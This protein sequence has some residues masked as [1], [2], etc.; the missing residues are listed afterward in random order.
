M[1]QKETNM[2]KQPWYWTYRDCMIRLAGLLAAA[3]FVSNAGA[4]L[5]AATTTPLSVISQS[6]PLAAAQKTEYD[7]KAAF[8]YN[9]I[10]FI[11]WSESKHASQS[12]TNK[13]E[14]IRIGVLGK[15]PFG[16]AFEPIIN[17]EIQGRKIQ[18]VEFKSFHDFCLGYSSKEKA[19]EAYQEAYFETL[20][21]CEILFICD[22]E[23]DYRQELLLM[24]S[25][26]AV[27]TL[28]D[29]DGFIEN[30]GMIGFLV[31]NNKVRFEI[32]L[33]NVHKENVKIGSQL[34]GLAK[35]VIKNKK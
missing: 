13:K 3:V 25:G 31:E 27:V 30:G 23:K 2:L 11:D 33:D 7:I 18:L 16:S 12:S 15:N 35:R 29:L 5:T 19:M 8:I 20:R 34:L 24:V 4:D 32:N 1:K 10:K 17:K 26:H 14:P 6:I 28:S 22:T 21:R 9:F